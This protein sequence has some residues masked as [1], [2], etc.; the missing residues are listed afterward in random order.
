METP[1]SSPSKSKEGTAIR[2]DFSLDRLEAQEQE[3]IQHIRT[4][5]L[6]K[7]RETALVDELLAVRKERRQIFSGLIGHIIRLQ[8]SRKQL[9][10]ELQQQ[11][12]TLRDANSSHQLDIKKLEDSHALELQNHAQRL[13]RKYEERLRSIGAKLEQVA[14]AQRKDDKSTAEALAKEMTS[15]ALDEAEK[16]HSA[17]LQRYKEALRAVAEKEKDSEAVALKQGD[18]ARSYQREVQAL[19]VQLEEHKTVI[20]ELTSRDRSSAAALD[21][22]RRALKT[23]QAEAGALRVEIGRLRENADREVRSLADAHMEE[24]VRVEGKVKAA[25][26]RREDGVR[27]IKAELR[28]ALRAKEAAERVLADLKNSLTI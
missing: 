11:A 16:M 15:V 27:G 19:K 28:E 25:L 24:L 5:G 26:A 6:R 13:T 18:L 2:K 14:H 3:I 10:D 21:G 7:P 9:S 1:P 23:E 8:A 22:V 17:K 20:S 4:S 12:L